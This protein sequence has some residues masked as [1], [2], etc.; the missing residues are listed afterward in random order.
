VIAWVVPL[1]YVPV[2]VYCCVEFKPSEMLAGVAAIDSST[3]AVT[4]RDVVPRILPDVAEIVV[5][6]ATSVVAKPEMLTVATVI[7]LEA[8]M[9]LA[10]RSCV[11]PS[12]YV[13]VAV[14]CSV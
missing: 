3:G 11:V 13:P 12:E 1:L 6:P 8:H 7:V 10:V 9:T 4:V 14:N 2:A 5:L